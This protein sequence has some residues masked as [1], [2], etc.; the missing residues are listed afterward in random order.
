MRK[1]NATILGIIILSFLIGIFLYPSMPEK[2]ASHWDSKG[3]VNGY[4]PKFWGLFLI[5]FIMI[6]LSLLFIAIPRIDPLKENI[7]KFRK[8][9]E[10][11]VILF[12]IFI[13]FIYILTILWNMGVKI[14]PNLII[15]P[16]IGILFFYTGILLQNAKRNWFIGIRTPW[17]LSSERVWDKT[18]KIGGKLFKAAGVIAFAGILLP[19]YAIF[20]I[21][22]PV[23]FSAF[24]VVVYSYIE[25]EREN[26]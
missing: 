17:T 18:H 13:F 14:N 11:F 23:F 8:Y 24:Y 7:E 10:I 6:L 3:N 19:D 20:F 2:M 22:L 5:P 15:S 4:I 26:R 16:S 9:Y 21:L 12:L 1:Y 25:Y